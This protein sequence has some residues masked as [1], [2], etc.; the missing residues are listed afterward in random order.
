MVQNDGMVGNYS[1][2]T[3]IK[4]WDSECYVTVADHTSWWPGGWWVEWDNGPDVTPTPCLLHYCHLG[5]L[6]SKDNGLRA[7][8]GTLLSWGFHTIFSLLGAKLSSI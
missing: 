1:A 5:H 2:C 7:T 4:H 6:R 8:Y 3:V